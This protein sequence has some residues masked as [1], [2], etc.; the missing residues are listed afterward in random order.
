MENT[1]IQMFPLIEKMKGLVM[2]MFVAVCL[3]S[4]T[5]CFCL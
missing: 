3:P 2:Q 1:H 4:Y 5:P